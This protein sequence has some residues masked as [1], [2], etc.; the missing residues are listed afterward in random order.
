MKGRGD[1]FLLGGAIGFWGGAIAFLGG[2][3]RSVYD[4]YKSLCCV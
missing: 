3:G 2:R 1:R 4:G